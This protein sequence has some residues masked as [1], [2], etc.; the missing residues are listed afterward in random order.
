MSTADAASAPEECAPAR[1][2]AWRRRR[3]C[4]IFGAD[5][6]H[7]SPHMRRRSRLLALRSLTLGGWVLGGLACIDPSAQQ[8]TSQ[9]LVDLGDQLNA[10]RQDNAVLQQQVDSLSLVVARQDTLLRRLA[11][12]AGIPQP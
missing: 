1:A 10:F 7:L 6:T 3:P 2:R 11:T 4:V 12:M 5:P 8:N 9:A